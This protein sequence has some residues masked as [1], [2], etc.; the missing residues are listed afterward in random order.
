[1]ATTTAMEV[2]SRRIIEDFSF[3]PLTFQKELFLL[4]KQLTDV[5]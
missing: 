1:M 4:A 2:D 3:S 5:F